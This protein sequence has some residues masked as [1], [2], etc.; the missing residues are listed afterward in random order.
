MIK[1]SL[2]A[3]IL[4]WLAVPVPV[5][6]QTDT[7]SEGPVKMLVYENLKNEDVLKQFDQR[8]EQMD[9]LLQHK[10]SVASPHLTLGED[11][12]SPDATLDSLYRVKGSLEEK[13]FKRRTGLEVTGQVYMRMDD[14]MVIEHDEDDPYSTYIDKFQA[15]IGWNFFNSAFYQRKTE[16]A[17]I[18]LANELDYIKESRDKNRAIY[19]AAENLLTM[20]YNYYMAIVLYNE[21][22]NVDI[23]NEAYQYMLEQDKISNDK[24][25]ENINDK[26]ELEYTLAQTFDI[27]DIANEPLYALTPTIITVDSVRL[28]EEVERYNPDLRASFVE[29]E[30]IN[31]QKKL[32]NYGQTMR[33][34]PFLRGSVYLRKVLSPSSNIDLG[35]RFTFPLYDESGPKRKALET[36]R[37]IV[38]EGRQS[39][40]EDMKS[41]CR[42]RLDRIERLNRA[43]RT[44][45]FHIEQ[46]GKYVDLRRNAYV[47]QPRGYNYIIRLEEYNEYL[48]SMERLYKLMLNRSLALL[49]IQKTTS[50]NNLQTLIIETPVK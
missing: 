18:R 19:E 41:Y 9:H 40:S 42:L 21:L 36:E 2:R 1:N 17:R 30:L 37:K 46:L 8:F 7:L 10:V 31:T 44:E 20:E 28:F 15:E 12:L 35:V 13:A 32:T 33:L 16:L 34:S 23:L 24:L 14:A 47:K 27:K 48:K 25:L 26:M 22:Q 43:I 4:A 38:V 49:D 50:Y 5:C 45:S 11:V 3:L 6:A 39:L 29:E